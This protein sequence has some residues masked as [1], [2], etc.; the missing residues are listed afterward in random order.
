MLIRCR[1]TAFRLAAQIGAL[2]LL[3]LSGAAHVNAMT[4]SFN[5]NRASTADEFAI[6]SSSKLSELDNVVAAG[7]NFVRLRFGTA[8]ARGIGR[9]L[10]R[11]R[12]ACGSDQSCILQRQI[13]AIRTYQRLGAQIMLPQWVANSPPETEPSS[14][15]PVVEEKPT[16]P[17]ME[18]PPTPEPQPVGSAEQGRRKR[19]IQTAITFRDDL[20]LYLKL[21]PETPDIAS[22]AQEFSKLQSALGNEDIATIE[23]TTKTLKRRMEAVSGFPEFRSDRDKDRQKAEVEA[24]G[25]AV[26]L[27]SKYQRFLRNQIAE[28]VTSPSTPALATLLNEYENALR[29]PD[30]STLTDLN[31]R[32]QKLVSEKGLP[33]DWPEQKAP[34]DESPTEPKIIKTD[35]NWFLVDGELTDWV[36]VFNASGKAPHVVKNIRGDIVFEGQQ[37][38]ACVLH[39]PAGK[40]ERVDV[41]DILAS[42]K[43]ETVHLNSAACPETNLKSYDVLMALR[44]ELL[45]QPPS[46][47]APLFGLVEDGT[48][49]ELETLT[50]SAVISLRKKW[51]VEA[52]KIETEIEAGTRP[53]YGLIKID[54]GSAV[55]CMTTADAEQAAQRALLNEQ[56]KVLL[57]FFNA[58]P[59]V[60]STTADA[61]FTAAK[62][63]Q[64]GAIYAGRSDLWEAIQGLRRDKIPYSL[65]PLWYEPKEVTDRSD[66]IR[67]EKDRLAEGRTETPA[68][69]GRRGKASSA[70]GA[71]PPAQKETQEAEL[72]HSMGHRHELGLRRSPPRSS[73]SRRIRRLGQSR[74]SRTSRAGIATA[75]RTAGSTSR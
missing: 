51:E 24:L 44:G 11:Q 71:G 5:C 64:C 31:D 21:H 40:I 62:R 50:S 17:A 47:L 1:Q 22:I 65:V 8:K 29:S 55:I 67:L 68:T 7:F 16:P 60:S 53:G 46:Y 43:V 34:K 2:G 36:L 26:S 19:V 41:E 45:K 58:A 49:Q 6:C 73:S 38:D 23:A 52:T 63:G 37:A 33:P 13:D 10:L 25:A 27:A 75:L 9:P 42:Y 66:E 3:V 32:L 12:Q 48:F 18:K 35:R 57:R 15:P 74:S 54:N 56:R 59:E 28:N 72:Q 14:P 39:P 30:L 20:D 69:K 61:A 70:E 4:P